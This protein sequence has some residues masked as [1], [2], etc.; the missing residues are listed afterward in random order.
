MITN[1][2]VYTRITDVPNVLLNKMNDGIIIDI[3][4]GGM[5][6]AVKEHVLH[7]HYLVVS[8]KLP[9]VL[10]LLCKVIWVDKDN[11]NRNYKVALRFEGISERDRDK[12]IRFI[13]E[14]MRNQSKM[15]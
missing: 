14:R 5:R 13:F 15:L 4:G 2:S 3:S 8:V 9:E 10:N 12:I 6:L 11:I 7:G 1:D